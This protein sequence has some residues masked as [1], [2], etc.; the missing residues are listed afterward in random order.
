R[1]HGMA[2]I[3]CELYDQGLIEAR[4]IQQLETFRAGL[5]FARSEGIV[6]GPEPTHAIAAVIQEALAAKEANEK[7]VILFNLSGHGHFDM[8][9]YD[10]YLSGQLTDYEY[11]QAEIDAAIAA[12]PQI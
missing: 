5:Q 11:P 1:Y 10:A 2:S 9:A 8:S 12:L 3:V 4:A 7:R 6:P